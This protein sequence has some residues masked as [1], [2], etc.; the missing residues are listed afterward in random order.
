[1]RAMR[2][3]APGAPPWPKQEQILASSLFMLV[4]L[5]VVAWLAGREVRY[6][7]FAVPHLHLEDLLAG[8]AALV[9]SLALSALNRAIRSEGERRDMMVHALA[10]RTR[11]QWRLYTATALAA[12]IAEEAAYRGIGMAVLWWVFGNWYVAALICAA[13]FAAAHAMQ[14]WKSG[15]TVF[16][17]ALLMHGLV[18]YTDTLVIA[19]VVHAIYDMLAGWMLAR[20][21]DNPQVPASSSDTG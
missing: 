19:M 18:E 17:M 20:E 1:M 2:A 21:E 8:L 6:S 11:R 14:G 7:F 15:V 10:P 9:I 3:G 12:G 13:A 4:A 5:F 16:L